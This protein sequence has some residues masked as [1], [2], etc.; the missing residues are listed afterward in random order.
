MSHY[1]GTE[2]Y[3]YPDFD[4]DQYL[5]QVIE[6]GELSSLLSLSS[7]KLDE[8]GETELLTWYT[9]FG[10]IGNIRGKV[11]SYQPT[12]HHGLGVI[13]FPLATPLAGAPRVGPLPTAID[14]SSAGYR[15]YKFPEPEAYNLNRLLYT[16][17]MKAE[18]RQRFVQ[19]MDA[20]LTEYRLRPQ[21][22]AA[23]KTLEPLRVAGAG[24]HPILAWT[25]VHLVAADM[26]AQG[27][28]SGS[29][30]SASDA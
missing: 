6:R 3:G 11:L 25:A 8:T 19:N 26:R 23:V 14:S 15:Y 5:L 9:V 29:S 7:E 13:D 12:W 16:L 10:A 22:I 20:M 30:Q 1:P 21:E 27:L 17:R 28:R 24:A 18:E 4:F 2:K